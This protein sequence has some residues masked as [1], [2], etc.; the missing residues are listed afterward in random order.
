MEAALL[1]H[2]GGGTLPL[3]CPMVLLWNALPQIHGS[4][5][6]EYEVRNA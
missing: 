3:L 6:G 2:S 5:R 4:M 1:P